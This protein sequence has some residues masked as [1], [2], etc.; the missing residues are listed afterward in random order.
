MLC[1]GV[2]IEASCLSDFH[3][4][5]RHVLLLKQPGPDG[6]GGGGGGS[7]LLCHGLRFFRPSQSLSAAATFDLIRH[8]LPRLQG[9]RCDRSI[10]QVS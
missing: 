3:S 5:Q 6:G 9:L 10:K 8:R 7:A 1:D 2:H 4:G